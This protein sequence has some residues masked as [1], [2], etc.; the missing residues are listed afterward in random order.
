MLA[1]IRFISADTSAPVFGGNS[2]RIWCAAPAPPATLA[3]KPGFPPFFELAR[4]LQSPLHRQ[5]DSPERRKK[6]VTAMSFH[7]E[8]AQRVA[9]SLIASL[10]VAAVMISAAV[11][12]LPIA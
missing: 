7:F 11:P 8:S 3:K 9:V 2:D 4:S 6:G 12:V 10:F 1:G 5:P